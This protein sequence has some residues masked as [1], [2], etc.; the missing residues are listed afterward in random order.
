[1]H[2]NN[3]EEKVILDRMLNLTNNKVDFDVSLDLINKELLS[4]E[5][6]ALSSFCRTMEENGF[7][8]DIQAVPNSR[9]G[10]AGRCLGFL[11]RVARKL[12]LRWYVTPYALRQTVYNQATTKAVSILMDTIVSLE[13][14]ISDTLQ[15]RDLHIEGIRSDVE[16]VYSNVETVR[17]NVETV[18]SDVETM[19]SDVETVHSDVETVRSDI[20][21][22]RSDVETICSNVNTARYDIESLRA[23]EETMRSDSD[24]M[25]NEIDTAHYEIAS[26]RTDTETVR[27]NVEAVR[28]EVEAVHTDACIYNDKLLVY[29]DLFADQGH[30]ELLSDPQIGKSLCKKRTP[31]QFPIAPLMS[32]AQSG[33]DAIITY[34]ATWFGYNKDKVTYLDIGANHAKEI[35]NTYAFYLCGARGVLVEANPTLIK[36]LRIGRS[37]DVVLHRC[38][39]NTSCKTIP[40]YVLNGDGLSTPD[41]KAAEDF[42]TKNPVLRIEETVNVQTITVND[43]MVQYFAESPPVLLNIDI[44][45]MDIEILKSIDFTLYRPLIIIVEMIPYKT[46]I[47]VDDKNDEIM[48]HMESVGYT[49]YAFTGI[50]SVFI[51]KERLESL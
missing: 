10:L 21:T 36:E 30:G 1:M 41:L 3:I 44:E 27:S 13:S 37:G 11:R 9:G 48:E 32:Y 42:I 24:T 7:N 26:I 14:A 29:F 28:S 19:R 25:R 4:K 47:V 40:F 46:S 33:E 39:S 38:V 22:M 6:S 43:I 18:R 50:N 23:D 8:V 34:I 2:Y 20:E 12:F 17:S 51:D 35:S 49:E 45:G 31:K 5:L 16:T 15:S